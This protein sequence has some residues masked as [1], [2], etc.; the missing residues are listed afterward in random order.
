MKEKESPGGVCGERQ[1]NSGRAKASGREK[2]EQSA[3]LICQE[4]GVVTCYLSSRY[5]SIHDVLLI[6]LHDNGFVLVN[7]LLPMRLN[8]SL[9]LTET[10]FICTMKAMLFFL[11]AESTSCKSSGEPAC[12]CGSFS[13]VGEPLK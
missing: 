1:Q 11:P 2:Q 13:D 10:S 7:E 3:V 9:I 12:S 6:S 4:A 5:S 8:T